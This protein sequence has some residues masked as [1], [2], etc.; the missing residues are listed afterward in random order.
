MALAIVPGGII[1]AA[2]GWY[3]DRQPLAPSLRAVVHLA[4]AAW[5]LFWLGGLPAVS[6]GDSR[7]ALGA[8][9]AVLGTIGI[10][11]FINLYN[12][13]DGID[14]LAAVEAV[15][16]GMVV[17]A[18]LYAVGHPRLAA[19]SFLVAAAVAGFLSWNWAPARIFMG[20]VGSGLLGFAF[21]AIA[22]AAENARALPIP[23]AVLLLGTFVFDAT[24]TLGR[25]VLRGDR[26]Y[27]AHRS[28]AYQRAV[29]GGLRHSTVSLV[30][31]A[32]NLILGGLAF[33]GVRHPAMQPACIAIGV[34]GL[35][36]L[37]VAVERR[38]P[39]RPSVEPPPAYSE[40]EPNER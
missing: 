7:I 3:D 38:V 11:W 17:G 25:R 24:I 34:A 1:V 30:V 2:I 16:V 23:L 20:D 8:A 15:S 6:V 10:V 22:V 19:L 32:A 39:M 40:I 12:F 29:Q 36:A 35:V 9:G 31:A 37:Y 4:A 28:H 18:I 26:W 21:G 5:A 14:G 27:T 33:Y 13:M